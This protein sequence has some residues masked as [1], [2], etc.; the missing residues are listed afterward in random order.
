MFKKPIDISS[1]GSEI[2]GKLF[3][4]ASQYIQGIRIEVVPSRINSLNDKEHPAATV[5]LTIGIP[6]IQ[7]MDTLDR[8]QQGEAI[9]HELIHLLLVYRFGLGVIGLKTP[10]HGDSQ[11]LFKFCL[12]LNKHWGYLLGQIV[13]TAHHLILIDYLKEEYGIRSDLHLRLLQHNFHIIANE[14][15]WDRESLYAKGLIAFEYEKLIGKVDRVINLYRQSEF[16]WKAYHAAEKHFGGYRSQ[17]IP[18][19]SYYKEDILSFLEDLA[20]QREDFIFFPQTAPDSLPNKENSCR[21][22]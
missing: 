11:E 1:L 13:N 2:L 9:A 10:R 22:Y 8:T 14:I 19:S 20:Y 12:N 17:S 4:E 16:F 6:T 5:G 15:W 18:I 21:P 7:L 3:Y